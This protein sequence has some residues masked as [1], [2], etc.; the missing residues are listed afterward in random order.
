V[1]MQSSKGS[2]IIFGVEVVAKVHVVNSVS[3]VGTLQN[4]SERATRIVSRN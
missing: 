4:I 2:L 3:T 1:E